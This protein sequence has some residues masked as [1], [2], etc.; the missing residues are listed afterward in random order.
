MNPCYSNGIEAHL[1]DIVIANRFKTTYDEYG[2]AYTYNVG[3][4]FAKIIDFHPNN[5]KCF[6]IIGLMIKIIEKQNV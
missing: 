6:E 4:C 1:N 5:K 3:L 2:E